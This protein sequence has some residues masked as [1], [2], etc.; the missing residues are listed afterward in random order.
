MPEQEELEE[1]R[2]KKA[3]AKKAQEQ[4][5]QTL[6]LALEEAAYDRLMNVSVANEELFLAAAKNALMFFKRAGR[7]ITEREV[8]ALL[9]AIKEQSETKTTIT[10]HKK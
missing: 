2:K 9:R 7:R 10:F 6:R 3:E 5:K 4:L 8:L 1:V